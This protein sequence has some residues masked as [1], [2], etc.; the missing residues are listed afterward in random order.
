VNAWL[1]LD[2]EAITVRILVRIVNLRRLYG[3]CRRRNATNWRLTV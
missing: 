1:R 2:F 3:R